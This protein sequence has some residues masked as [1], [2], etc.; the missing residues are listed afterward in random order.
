MLYKQLGLKNSDLKPNNSWPDTMKPNRVQQSKHQNKDWKSCNEYYK[1]MNE[2][3]TKRY[4]Y[5]VSQ[6]ADDEVILLLTKLVD[7][8]EFGGLHYL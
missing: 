4:D 2:E 6:T 8:N 7:C 1:Q 3:W 5:F